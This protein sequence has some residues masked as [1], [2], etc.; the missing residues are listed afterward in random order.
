[1]EKELR[2][3]MKRANKITEFTVTLIHCGKSGY[4]IDRNKYE[5]DANMHLAG[6]RAV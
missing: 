3:E 5:A 6:E 4:Y 1:V 2:V